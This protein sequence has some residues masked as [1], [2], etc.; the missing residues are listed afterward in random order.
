[1]NYL[2]SIYLDT[3]I[4]S[5]LFDEREEIKF[6]IDSTIEFWNYK[7]KDYNLFISEQTLVELTEGNY[8]RKDEII[9]FALKIT[10]LPCVNEIEEIV[11]TYIQNKIMLIKDLGDSYYLAYSSFYKVDYLLTWNYKHLA[12]TNK[13]HQIRLINN[14]LGLFVP[15]IVTP[16]QLLE[17]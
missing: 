14:R 11:K 17:E 5:F 10:I 13:Q 9:E 1:M 6:L 12:N 3:T 8:P 7:R 16:L 2:K 15:E 4:P